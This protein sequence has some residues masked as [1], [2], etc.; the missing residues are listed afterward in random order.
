MGKS[1]AIVGAGGIGFD[2]AEFLAHGADAQPMAEDRLT[3]GTLTL[4][5]ALALTLTVTLTLTLT[6][7]HAMPSVASFLA[8]YGIDPTNTARGG[9][10]SNLPQD[11][12]VEAEPGGGDGGGEGVGG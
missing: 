8:E 2:I 12:K 11:S 3:R 7:P 1:V 5:L 4:T 9:L 10:V 6:R